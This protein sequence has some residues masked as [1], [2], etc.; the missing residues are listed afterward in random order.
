M[1]LIQMPVFGYGMWW[2]DDG[3]GTIEERRD[4]Q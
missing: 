1:T 2:I 4:F 3:Q